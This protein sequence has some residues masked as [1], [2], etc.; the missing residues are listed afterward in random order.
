MRVRIFEWLGKEFFAFES[1]GSEGDAAEQTRQVF[2]RLED[3]LRLHDLTLHDTVRT[4]LWARE[5]TQRDEASRERY[6]ILSGPSRSVSSSY[7][8]P[9]HFSMPPSLVSIDLLAMRQSARNKVPVEREPPAIP[10]RYLISG[11]ACFLSGVSSP[12]GN[13]ERQVGDILESI[14][15][16]LAHAG[17]SWE[18][19]ARVIAFLHRGQSISLLRRLLAPRMH[20][21]PLTIGLVDGYSSVGKLVE[22]EVTARA[23]QR[24]TA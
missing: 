22:V 21:V 17:T 24:P 4:R 3:A 12:S 1:H 9:D 23:N 10:L 13:L 14:D 18:R 6:R 19:V 16:T 7:I 15:A 5:P 20:S 8:A 11:R 2:A